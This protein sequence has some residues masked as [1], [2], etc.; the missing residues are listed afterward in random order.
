M[1][2]WYFRGAGTAEEILYILGIL[3]NPDNR[4]LPFPLI[5]TGPRSAEGYFKQIHE[6][7]GLTL[8]AEAQSLYEIIIDDPA[9]V[10]VAMANKL[11]VV[12]AFRRQNQDAYYFNW[13]LRVAPD[14]QRPFQPTH[15]RMRQLNLHRNQEP[16]QLAAAL[17]KAFSAI[18]DGNVKEHGIRAVAE[19]GPYEIHG[20]LE[21]LEPLS[22]LLRAFVAA[23]RMKIPTKDY[24]PCYKILN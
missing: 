4:R 13:L 23:K 17:R 18:V 16:H 21:I 19:K 2:L 15:E 9:A 10:A 1:V 14:F 8:G 12:R 6:F 24:V 22:E 11:E 3:L 20:E 5:F 7:I